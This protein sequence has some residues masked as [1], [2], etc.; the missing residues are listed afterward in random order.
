VN[1]VLNPSNGSFEKII[2]LPEMFN[3]CP[4]DNEPVVRSEVNVLPGDGAFPVNFLPLAG[5]AS[6]LY[7]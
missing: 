4:S 3:V 7:V 2:R 1:F 6:G 5:R